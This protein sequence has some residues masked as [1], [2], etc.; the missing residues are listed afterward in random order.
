M[1]NARKERHGA[2]QVG[3]ALANGQLWNAFHNGPS[4]IGTPTR[5]TVAKKRAGQNVVDSDYLF[6]NAKKGKFQNR[7]HI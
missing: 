4:A 3:V 1:I 6:V 5:N 7:K 2:I